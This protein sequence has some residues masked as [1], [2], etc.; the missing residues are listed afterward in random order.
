MKSNVEEYITPIEDDLAS[1][2]YFLA[3]EKPKS[4]YEISYEI[5]DKYH[6]SII[7]KIHELKD[8]GYFNSIKIIG[9]KHPKW[10]SNVEPLISIIEFKLS[11]VKYKS[12]QIVKLN[13]LDKFILKKIL[14]CSFFRLIVVNCYEVEF[15]GGFNAVE[16]ILQQLD[17]YMTFFLKTKKYQLTSLRI[18]ESLSTI[19]EYKEFLDILK[20]NYTLDDFIKNFNNLKYFDSLTKTTK[21][22]SDILSD[23]DKTNEVYEIIKSSLCFFLIPT[24]LM[25]KI[26]GITIIGQLEP[27]LN[28]VCEYSGKFSI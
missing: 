2:I 17:Y 13:S 7:G 11:N 10:L 15:R 24:T 26:K 27:L 28:S 20:K 22:F 1:K 23:K 16:H 6:H 25:R 5:Y 19:K 8:L 14:D 9:K 4:A 21:E 12:Q 3:Y 18:E